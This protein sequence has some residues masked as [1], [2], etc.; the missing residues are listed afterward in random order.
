VEDRLSSGEIRERGWINVARQGLDEKTSAA[1]ARS[2]AYCKQRNL[3]L[4]LLC[5]NGATGVD[6]CSR[7]VTDLSR[8]RT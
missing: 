5:D 7:T 8:D 3:D 2:D 6:V 1:M 4:D